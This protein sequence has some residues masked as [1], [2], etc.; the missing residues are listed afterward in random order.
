M[1]GRIQLPISH[2]LKENYKVEYVD[3]ITEPGIDK[4]FLDPKRI[5][6][7]KPKVLIS[8]NAHRSRVIVVSAHYNCLGNPVSKKEHIAEVKKAMSIINSWSLPVKVL[9]VWVGKNWEVEEIHP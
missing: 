8:V 3:T 5:A 4:S 7:I 2:W 1:D 9:G 6:Q